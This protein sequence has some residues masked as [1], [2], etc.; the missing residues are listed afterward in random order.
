[1][2]VTRHPFEKKMLDAVKNDRA[3]ITFFNMIKLTVILRWRGMFG[4]KVCCPQCGH[5]WR[6]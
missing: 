1:M 4:M 5:K 2:D 3:S 6:V